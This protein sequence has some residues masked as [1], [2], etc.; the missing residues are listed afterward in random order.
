MMT[1]ASV[2]LTQPS[3]CSAQ[4]WRLDSRLPW[5]PRPRWRLIR[6]ST[7]S[8]PCTNYSLT[9]LLLASHLHRQQWRSI[10]TY[11][12]SPYCTDT[13]SPEHSACK[14]SYAACRGQ[15][16]PAAP[17]AAT[18]PALVSSGHRRGLS[19]RRAHQNRQLD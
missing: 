4:R 10:H 3:L 2:G 9:A 13:H 14:L 19:E 8:R 18:Y 1:L 11:P 12:Y 7:V 15:G 5:L 16:L 17:A 6:R